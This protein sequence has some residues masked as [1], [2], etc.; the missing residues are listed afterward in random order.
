MK[1]KRMRRRYMSKTWA[2]NS[3]LVNTGPIAP[4]YRVLAEYHQRVRSIQGARHN[5]NPFTKYTAVLGFTQSW[6][7]VRA[8]VEVRPNSWLDWFPTL[9][10]TN[11]DHDRRQHVE[12]FIPVR[13]SPKTNEWKIVVM[14]FMGP[15]AFLIMHEPK[16]FRF[17]RSSY[18][19]VAGAKRA[20]QRNEVNWMDI[21]HY[22]PPS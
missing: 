7:G 22:T 13:L 2:G 18:Y 14:Y 15:R 16:Q 8:D 21:Y 4:N 1:R 19:T 5:A 11:T 20:Y 17:R 3:T 9:K 6:D 10:R 12:T